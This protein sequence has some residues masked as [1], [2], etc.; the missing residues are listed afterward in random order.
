GLPP[1][2]VAFTDGAFRTRWVSR[3]RHRERGEPDSPELIASFPKE[4]PT[5]PARAV[6]PPAAAAPKTQPAV[7]QPP[8]PAASAPPKAVASRPQAPAARPAARPAPQVVVAPDF[9]DLEEEPP[10]E[11]QPAGEKTA[12]HSIPDGFRKG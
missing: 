3:F 8:R 1:P 5:A 10:S 6:T 7:A 2:P 11:E 9:S 4:A 12:L